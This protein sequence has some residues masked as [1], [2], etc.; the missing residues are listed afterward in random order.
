MYSKYNVQ[1][2]VSKMMEEKR[3]NCA[4]AIFATYGPH[5]ESKNID[6]GLCLNIAAAFGGG[7]N[8]TG[9]VC[10]AITGSLMVLGLKYGENIQELTR[11]SS[12]L[13]DEFKAINGSIICHELIGHNLFDVENLSKAFQ[14]DVFKK[15]MKCVNDAA[16]L[17]EKHLELEE[18][19]Q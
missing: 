15:C 3:G 8:L 4:Q 12:Q 11:I 13:M 9:N 10:G 16:Q 14:Q 18:S 17:L 6:H 2:T 5:I 19:T 7:I 1:E